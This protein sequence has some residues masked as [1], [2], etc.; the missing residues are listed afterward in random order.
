MSEVGFAPTTSWLWTRRMLLVVLLGQVG[1]GS[2]ITLRRS[3]RSGER[4][5]KEK[6]Q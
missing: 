6:I 4:L 5:F 2:R 3:A 1:P